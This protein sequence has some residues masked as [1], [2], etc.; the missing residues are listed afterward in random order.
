MK[1]CVIENRKYKENIKT[2][3]TYQTLTGETITDIIKSSHK[4]NWMIRRINN[5]GEEVY[6]KIYKDLD[7]LNH[8]DFSNIKTDV[9][10]EFIVNTDWGVILDDD[11]FDNINDLKKKIQQTKQELYFENCKVVYNKY[12]SYNGEIITGVRVQIQITRDQFEQSLIKRSREDLIDVSELQPLE[13]F[14]GYR[15]AHGLRGYFRKR[16]SFEDAVKTLINRKDVHIAC[17]YNFCHVGDIGVYVKGTCKFAHNSDLSSLCDRTT[18]KR[19]V[20][21]R[22]AND[23]VKSPED[24]DYFSRF[25]E[26][27]ITDFEIVGLW[28]RRG[29]FSVKELET[30]KELTGLTNVTYVH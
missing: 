23:V 17:T 5:Y 20:N 9:E 25:G 29:R 27:I 24:I 1:N 4:I 2:L 21:K 6:Q 14:R 13:G 16:I 28:V 12:T 10:Y 11:T 3:L 22:Y 7:I 15:F 26:A 18:G 19:F 8:I 30:L